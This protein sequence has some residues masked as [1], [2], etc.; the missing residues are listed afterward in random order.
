MIFETQILGKDDTQLRHALR[1]FVLQDT[2]Y[3]KPY[4]Q[5]NFAKIQEGYSYWGQ[6]DSTNQDYRDMLHS[7]VISEFHPPAD[8][9]KEFHGF[10]SEQ[11]DELQTAVRNSEL[12][13]IEQLNIPG[14]AELYHSSLGHMVSCNYY[15][16]VMNAPITAIDNTRL[17]RHIDV[18]LFSTFVFGL[19]SGFSYLNQQGELVALGK[20]TKI[21]SFPGYLLEVLTEGKIKALQHQVDLPE[22]RQQE[23][24]SFAFFSIP[25]PDS[26]LQMGNINLS[27][28]QY[29]KQYLS[30]YF[31]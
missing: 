7:F 31:D 1:N 14:L 19:D 17:M 12:A 6:T 5:A 9:P 11:W 30:L 22:N 20:Q 8:F 2:E 10:F 28:E 18:S 21:I 13:L 24:F 16:P 29:L 27:S 23:R 25:K 4:L 15:P 3:K 26:Q